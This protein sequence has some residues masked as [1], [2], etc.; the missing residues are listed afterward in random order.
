MLKMIL[1]T[2]INS[3][4]YLSKKITLEFKIYI[5]RITIYQKI[6]SFLELLIL[7]VI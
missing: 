7:S 5:E 6:E 2:K 1:K 3:T 4:V